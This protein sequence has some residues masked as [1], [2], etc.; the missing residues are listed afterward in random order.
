[1]GE[2]WDSVLPLPPPPHRFVRAPSFALPPRMVVH[3]GR[4]AP[5]RF[6]L[7]R[8]TVLEMGVCCKCGFSTNFDLAAE[9]CCNHRQTWPIPRLPAAR[10]Q[11]GISMLQ[12]FK[13]DRFHV[14]DPKSIAVLV[15]TAVSQQIGFDV[16]PI[17]AVKVRGV[18]GR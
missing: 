4:L 18:L 12:S 6:L 2:L 15:C 3:I 16:S 17:P 8:C 10:R 14:G 7:K 5:P 13:T 1:M 9:G 11:E